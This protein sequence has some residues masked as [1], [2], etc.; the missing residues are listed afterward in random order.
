[1]TGINGGATVSSPRHTPR[2]KGRSV[3]PVDVAVYIAPVSKRGYATGKW[4]GRPLSGLPAWQRF[5]VLVGSG[6]ALALV[7]RVLGDRLIR[8]VTPHI[9]GD[10]DDIVFRGIHTA[11]YVTVGLGGA[12]AGAQIY[13]IRPAIAVSLEAGTLSWSSSS[14]W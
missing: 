6:V 8:R 7:I 3:R 13:D 14:G 10:V 11:V 12:Y 1:M 5:L 2:D 9:E 4:G